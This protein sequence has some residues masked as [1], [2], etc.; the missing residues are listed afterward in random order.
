ML[1]RT[2]VT[3]GEREVRDP[4]DVLKY[5]EPTEATKIEIRITPM[6]WRN[7]GHE[8]GASIALSRWIPAEA[9]PMGYS[10][11]LQ[12]MMYQLYELMLTLDQKRLDQIALQAK[13]DA[14][15]RA[16]L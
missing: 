11:E 13:L 4:N 1:D 8:A 5:W 6:S 12:A 9:G 16:E 14:K 7:P 2:N 3:F 10:H 15:N